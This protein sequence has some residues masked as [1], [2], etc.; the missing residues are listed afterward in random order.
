MPF[1]RVPLEECLM[2]GPPL[3]ALINKNEELFSAEEAL[4][5]GLARAVKCS[6]EAAEGYSRAN[7][8]IVEALDT[9]GRFECQQDEDSQGLFGGAITKEKLNLN[10]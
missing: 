5:M 2:D 9:L 10:V 8:V 1:E 6:S 7:Y 4:R 3:A